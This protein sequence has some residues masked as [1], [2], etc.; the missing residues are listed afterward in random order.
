MLFRRVQKKDLP[1][2]YSL[3]KKAGFGLTSL[4][5]DEEE[6]SKRIEISERSFKKNGKLPVSENYFFVLED[7]EKKTVV[8]TSAIESSVGYDV[9]WYAYRVSR[10]SKVCKQLDLHLEHHTLMLN[11]DL[12]GFSEIATLYL[13]KDYRKNHN[14]LLLSR[15]RFLFMAAFP[16]RFSEFVIA[17]MRGM[18]DSKGNSPFWESLGKH[19]F[20]IPFAEAD[21]LTGANQKQFIADLLP[22]TII[23]TVMLSKAAQ[24][25]IGKPHQSTKPAMKILEKEGFRYNGY[26]DIFDAGPTLKARV[27]DIKT[28]KSSKQLRIKSI[29]DHVHA[30]HFFIGNDSLDFR[31]VHGELLV[32]DDTCIMSRREAELLKVKVGDMIR[33][34]TVRSK[35]SS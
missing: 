6:L 13:D 31:A 15:S 7:T 25:V 17:E 3:A 16:K 35:T 10:V 11:N 30:K 22:H 19:F 9:P 2:I 21:A 26:V 32:K 12:N 5:K 8:G 24:A 29:S 27:Q 14:G 34:A 4:C 1:G 28:V 33:A 20:K 18:S 23:Y